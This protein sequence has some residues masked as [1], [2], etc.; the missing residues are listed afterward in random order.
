[1][2]RSAANATAATECRGR[3]KTVRFHKAKSFKIRDRVGK[4][5]AYT[6]EKAARE[7]DAAAAP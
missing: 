2:A 6:A 7:V 5:T 4:V 1:M 3:L